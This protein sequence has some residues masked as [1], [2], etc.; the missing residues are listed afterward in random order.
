MTADRDTRFGAALAGRL[1]LNYEHE[2]AGI[3]TGLIL[4][5]LGA[6]MHAISPVNVSAR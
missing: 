2:P 5:A 3:D 6:D 4:A 1:H